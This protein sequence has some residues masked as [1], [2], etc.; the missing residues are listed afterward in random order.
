MCYFF[1]QVSIIAVY[2]KND[3]KRL[4]SLF[5]G[6]MCRKCVWIYCTPVGNRS[7]YFIPLGC[8]IFISAVPVR[9]VSDRK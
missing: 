4:G 6:R 3:I 1:F 7:A 8:E 5:C 9:K 2:R